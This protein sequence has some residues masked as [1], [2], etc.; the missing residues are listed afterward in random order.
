MAR[1]RTIKPE[2]WDSP[3]TAKAS[4]WA[5]L[6]FIAMWNWADDYGRGTAN[7]K[8]ME[9]FAFPHDDAF[10]DSSGNTVHFRSLVAEVSECFGVVFYEVDKRP[11][12]EI[13]TWDL[14]QRNERRSKQSKY[15]AP[16]P[17]MGEQEEKGPVAEIP[18]NDT[19][20]PNISGAGT[21]EQGNR[22][23]GDQGN[24]GTVEQTSVTLSDADA[25]DFDG[26]EFEA[27]E[28]SPTED[29]QAA[30]GYPED[31]KRFWEIYPRRAGKGAACASFIK[32]KK[33]AKVETIIAGAER[34]RDDPNLPE[35]SLIAH[36]S[37]WLNQDRWE[38][39]PMPPR[40]DLS[41]S[42][43]RLQ[44]GFDLVQRVA[45]RSEETYSYDPFAGKAIEQ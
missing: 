12:Y 13:P 32:A 27:E 7:L 44:Q 19:E 33:R 9:G 41:K 42:D 23:T 25:P 39:D 28:E 36:P 34:L 5:R 21:G 17:D 18:C 3:S 4:P 11:Y 6:L 16:N 31:F 22:G 20:T 26:Q 40:S 14:H 2:F 38:D 30:D 8:E 43:Q 15:P 1:I 29:E 35:G 10:T 24:S 37:T 45:A